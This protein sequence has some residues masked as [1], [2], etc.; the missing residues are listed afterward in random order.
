MCMPAIIQGEL[1]LESLLASC[2]HDR[3]GLMRDEALACI[4][5][6]FIDTPD[7][8]IWQ[9]S[10][11]M[12]DGKVKSSTHTVVRGRHFTEIGNDFYDGNP[13]ARIDQWAVEQSKGDFIRLMNP[14]A[15]VEVDRMVWYAKGDMSAC[16]KLVKDH[17]QWIGKRR[18]SGMGE[19]SAVSVTPWHGDPLLDSNGMV[20]RPIAIRRLRHLPGSLDASKQRVLHAVDQH[21]FWL[22]EPELCAM[23]ISR[24]EIR[25]LPATTGGEMFFG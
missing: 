18:G 6:D 5:I 23:P 14:Y 15:Q 22:H 24:K 11:V 17:V 7:G 8:K 12:F 25:E 16:E 9:A 4:P 19:V 10:S 21:P 3:D 20:R 1:P 13:R 2:I